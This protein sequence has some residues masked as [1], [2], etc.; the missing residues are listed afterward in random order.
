[1]HCYTWLDDNV[2]IPQVARARPALYKA[3]G[4]EQ[5]SCFVPSGC[6]VYSIRVK[7]NKKLH[8]SIK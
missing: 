5:C 2:D 8:F 6:N 1:M 7:R 4:V 3:G